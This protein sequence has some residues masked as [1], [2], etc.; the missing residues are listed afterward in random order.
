MLLQDILGTSKYLVYMR[1]IIKQG[2][3][4]LK[5][6]HNA[7][8]FFE[9]KPHYKKNRMNKRYVYVAMTFHS[10][11]TIDVWRI[12]LWLNNK[13]IATNRT[14]NQNCSQQ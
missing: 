6:L 3:M 11:Y 7:S 12:I 1:C 10:L 9:G 5:P 4:V 14:F 8:N 2:C 13:D